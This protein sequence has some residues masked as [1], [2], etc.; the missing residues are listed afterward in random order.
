MGR[1]KIISEQGKGRYTVEVQIQKGYT[2]NVLNRI[3]AKILRVGADITNLETELSDL[4]YDASVQRDISEVEIAALESQ[5]DALQ[6][7]I[8]SLT[9]TLTAYNE[10]LAVLKKAF[11]PDPAAIAAKEA[12]ITSVKGQIKDLETQIEEREKAIDAE[13]QKMVAADLLVTGTEAKIAFAKAE[14]VSLNKRYDVIRRLGLIYNYN[15]VAWCCDLTEGLSVGRYVPTIEIG[16]E[17]PEAG[18]SFINIFPAYD[19]GAGLPVFS[20]AEHG[21]VLPFISMPVAD[22][23]RN[24]CAMPAIQKWAPS[25]RWGTISAINYENDTCSVNVAGA[26]SHVQSL[27]INQSGSLTSVPI[28]Y[29]FCNSGAFEVGDEVVVEFEDHDWANAKVIGFKKEPQPCG[30]EEPWNGPGIQWKYPWV[31]RYSFILGTGTQATRTITNGIMTMSFPETDS[32]SGA[33]G[34]THY[35]QYTLY[36]EPITENVSKIKM[37]VASTVECYSGGACTHDYQLIVVGW[38]PSETVL[39]N[40]IA[41]FVYNGYWPHIGCEGFDYDETEWSLTSEGNSSVWW[42]PGGPHPYKIYEKLI[43]NDK[44]VFFPI[45]IVMSKVLAIGV[46][47]NVNWVGGVAYNQPDVIEGGSLAC[48]LI[49]LA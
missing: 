25:F 44:D 15:T 32:G 11:P 22:A 23:L 8:D 13:N 39:L 37:D 47:M 40:Y 30:W 10:E 7:N 46:E 4:Q 48:D 34:Q 6:V 21:E 28:E 35:L 5:I 9:G 19:D 24:F 2:N 41:K 14:L 45:P 18:T 43:D 29:M 1:A 17:Y 27:N 26:Y 3:N 38:D 12:Q 36:G 49:S 31:Y 16:T 33:L 20:I 42:L